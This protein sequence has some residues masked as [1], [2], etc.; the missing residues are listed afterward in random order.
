MSEILALSL[1][2]GVFIVGTVESLDEKTVNMTHCV[3]MYEMADPQDPRRVG[4]TWHPD[5]M[6]TSE[7]PMT[8]SMH[9]LLCYRK[10]AESEEMA[11]KYRAFLTQFRL[12]RSGL[13]S[14]VTSVE[15]QKKILTE[16]I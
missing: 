1:E 3:R 10:L 15:Q 4:L 2:L 14:G 11:V 16:G 6:M 7:L 5:P 9:N 8:F 12:S 13:V